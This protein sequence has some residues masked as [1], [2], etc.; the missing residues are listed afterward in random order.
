MMEGVVP[1]FCVNSGE[2]KESTGKVEDAPMLCINPKQL[3]LIHIYMCIRDSFLFLCQ[4]IYFIT[5]CIGFVCL[6]ICGAQHIPGELVFPSAVSYTHLDVY[7][8]QHECFYSDIGDKGCC[9]SV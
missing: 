8:R 6:W 5:I 3:S 1:Y 2:R 7:K 9:L 4:V